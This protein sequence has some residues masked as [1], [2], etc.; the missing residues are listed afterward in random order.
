MALSTECQQSMMKKEDEVLEE[1]VHHSHWIADG[2]SATKGQT[3]KFNKV[4]HHIQH[5]NVLELWSAP[6]G[7]W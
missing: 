5:V 4:L 2:D 7:K 1:M 3:K 6:G